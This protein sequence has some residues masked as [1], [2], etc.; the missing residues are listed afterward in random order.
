[1][2]SRTPSLEEA[3]LETDSQSRPFMTNLTPPRLLNSSTS[4]ARAAAKAGLGH[5]AAEHGVVQDGIDNGLDAGTETKIDEFHD[6]L[7]IKG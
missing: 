6:V 5:K 2:V 1:M 3:A 4:S 7:W